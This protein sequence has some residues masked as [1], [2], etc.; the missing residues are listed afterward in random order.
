MN[1]S[2]EL[3]HKI[4]EDLKN[5]ENWEFTDKAQV[6]GGAS[7]HIIR[8]DSPWCIS[9]LIQHRPYDTLQRPKG[10][11]VTVYHEKHRLEFTEEERE[12][13]WTTG[14]PTYQILEQ[15]WKNQRLAKANAAFPK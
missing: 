5:P 14:L 15:E 7:H 12:I 4:A 10:W 1:T 3:A 2:T 11:Y 8:K 6:P 9:G 13:I